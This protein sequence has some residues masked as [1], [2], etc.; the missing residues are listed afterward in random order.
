MKMLITLITAAL[1]LGVVAPST[2]QAGPGN[3]CSSEHRSVEGN[4]RADGSNDTAG[5]SCRPR[6]DRG[7]SRGYRG[8]GHRSYR[9]YRSY[10]GHRC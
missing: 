3:S 1:T 10:R 5:N 4:D 9:S 6:Y 7:H 8:H 2:A